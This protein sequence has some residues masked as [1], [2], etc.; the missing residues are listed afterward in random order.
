M[1]TSI[2]NSF[3][4]NKTKK[5]DYNTPKKSKTAL[6]SS[7]RNKKSLEKS[8]KLFVSGKTPNGYQFEDIGLQLADGDIEK[9]TF[10]QLKK[11]QA[12]LSKQV[13]TLDW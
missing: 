4:K 6:K 8:V 3:Q 13:W 10:E 5:S 11:Q 2:K 1:K 7:L 12:E 9:L